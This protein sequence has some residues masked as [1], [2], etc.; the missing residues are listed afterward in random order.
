M[1]IF[2]CGPL[3]AR[4][5]SVPVYRTY[6]GF[7]LFLIVFV[8]F[9]GLRFSKMPVV[10]GILTVLKK[11]KLELAEDMPRTVEF[12]PTAMVTHAKGGIHLKFTPH[13]P[14]DSES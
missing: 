9:S 14:Q 1:G 13:Q 4:C 3:V 5:E 7:S 2:Y 11:Y 10:A 6:A 8:L 12:Q